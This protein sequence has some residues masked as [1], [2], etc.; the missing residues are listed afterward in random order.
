MG[1]FE[2]ESSD[3]GLQS[4]GNILE[5]TV[6]APLTA[7]ITRFLNKLKPE[8][9]IRRTPLDSSCETRTPT[10]IP[11]MIPTLVGIPRMALVT[12]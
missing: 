3:G 10:M 5:F 2:S 7:R 6:I 11:M 9:Q 8:W 1:V 12:L 4:H